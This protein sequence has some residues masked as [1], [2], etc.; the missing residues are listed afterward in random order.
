VGVRETLANG[1]RVPLTLRFRD[2]AGKRYEASAQVQ[3][4]GLVVPRATLPGS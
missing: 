1:T 3:V 4:R 2:R